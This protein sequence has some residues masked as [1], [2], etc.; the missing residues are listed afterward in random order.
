M[1]G[2]QLGLEEGP[3]LL[4]GLR[5]KEA[6]QRADQ[7]QQHLLVVLLDGGACMALHY[8]QAPEANSH[9]CCV[10][11]KITHQLQ[12]QFLVVVLP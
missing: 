8:T 7:L 6:P 12:E 3:D 11:Y 5:G 9:A 10:I 4:S 1:Q 2:Q